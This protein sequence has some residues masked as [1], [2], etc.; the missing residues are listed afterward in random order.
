MFHQILSSV[1]LFSSLVFMPNGQ[2]CCGYP[3]DAINVSVMNVTAAAFQC[4]E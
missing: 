1:V 2:S 3:V 4:L